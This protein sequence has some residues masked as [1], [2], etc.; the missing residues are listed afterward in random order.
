VNAAIGGIHPSSSDKPIMDSAIATPKEVTPL[1]TTD[2]I[3]NT[4]VCTTELAT[5]NAYSSLSSTTVDLN[6][7]SVAPTDG[8]LKNV[9]T[10]RFADL[11]VSS[12]KGMNSKFIIIIS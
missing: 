9:S 2:T 6:L 4:I 10:S 1:S 3:L 7:D 5:S 8:V 12:T 11:L